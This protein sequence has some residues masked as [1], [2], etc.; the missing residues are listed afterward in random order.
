MV[1]GE[2]GKSFKLFKRLSNLPIIPLVGNGEQ[3]IQPVTID[4]IV[5]VLQQS[6]VTENT[7]QTIDVVGE[8]AISYKQWM[9]KIRS[10]KSQA[11]FLPIPMGLMN[12][13]AWLFSPLK[14]Q[15]LSKDNLSM[16]EQN[17]EGDYTPLKK[18]L[19][20]SQ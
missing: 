5:E 3:L 15:L 18:F 12:F 10:K 9:Q 11:R 1:Y 7:N 17:N 13:M 14:L 4:K 2:G 16:L 6:I 20:N 8:R 19:E